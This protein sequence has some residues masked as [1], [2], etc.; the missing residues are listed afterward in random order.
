MYSFPLAL[1]KA[2]QEDFEA[3]G[4]SR[5]DL[6]EICGVEYYVAARWLR[7]IAPD[8]E[9][10]P[11]TPPPANKFIQA[12]KAMGQYR[13]WQVGCE[14]LGGFFTLHP[15]VN[16]KDN[17][18]LFEQ[19][20]TLYRTTVNLDKAFRD[21]IADGKMTSKELNTIIRTATENM[22]ADQR[23]VE[24]ARKMLKNGEKK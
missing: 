2:F 23:I 6:A 17:L 1:W 10:R 24:C 20:A 18:S 4:L 13:A 14:E 3:S 15:Q 19:V 21:A 9:L 16:F 12:I 5:D 22:A 11:E 7:L 8:D